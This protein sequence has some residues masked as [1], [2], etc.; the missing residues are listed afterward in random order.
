MIDGEILP[1]VPAKKKPKQ[2]RPRKLGKVSQAEKNLVAQ[3]VA[4]SALEPSSGEVKA[5]AVALRRPISIVKRIIDDARDKFVHN[6]RD[7]VEIHHKAV[8]KALQN[9]DAKSLDVAVHGS[10]WAIEHT[11]GEGSR[12]VE[13]D[14]KQEGGMKV[15]IGVKIGGLNDGGS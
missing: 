11:S 10:A 15:L 14:A 6:A 4:D 9:G 13:K 1:A 12:I 3:V 5:L 2:R 8:K 7:Y